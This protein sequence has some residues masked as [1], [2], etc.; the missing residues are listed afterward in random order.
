MKNSA[1]ELLSIIKDISSIEVDAD[2]LVDL[3]WKS[4]P[5]EPFCASEF[6]SGSFTRELIELIEKHVAV[7]NEQDTTSSD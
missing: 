3:Y 7:P 6:V 1:K 5:R 2:G 4:N